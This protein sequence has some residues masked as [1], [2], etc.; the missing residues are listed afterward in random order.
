MAVNTFV[1]ANDFNGQNGDP[2]LHLRKFGTRA[3]RRDPG[4]YAHPWRS[5][6]SSGGSCR[7]TYPCGRNGDPQLCFRYG[8]L[9]TDRLCG[10][11]EEWN[12]IDKQPYWNLGNGEVQILLK[13]KTIYEKGSDFIG[14]PA[15]GRQFG[16]FCATDS[17][18]E[19]GRRAIRWKRSALPTKRSVIAMPATIAASTRANA[20]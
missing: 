9:R 19:H 14:Q 10:S 16:I 12:A 7:S 18:R 4:Q 11:E 17:H 3:E 1:R 13:E 20:R 5:V 6:L 15:Q 8:Q 2:V